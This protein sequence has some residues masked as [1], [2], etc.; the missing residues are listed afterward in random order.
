MRVKSPGI[1]DIVSERF[2]DGP[3][4][5]IEQHSCQ[6]ELLIMPT[7]TARI[8]ANQ[9][10]AAKSTGPKTDEG[11]ARSRL[12][13]F[14][15][16]LAGQ[17]DLIGP[18]DD[19]ALIERRT[20]AFVSELGAPGEVGALFAHRAAVLSVRMENAVV[21]ESK[22]IAESIQAGRDRFDDERAEQLEAW[23]V[24]AEE[25]GAPDIPLFK[26]ETC[27]E[28]LR[29]LRGAWRVMRASVER[30]DEAAT[31]RAAHW[32][33]LCRSDEG[34]PADLLAG[35]DAEITRLDWLVD[36]PIIQDETQL[37][38]T[39]RN[40]AGTI[41]SFDPGPEATLAR[42]YEAAAERGM[43][44]AIR[45]IRELRR[46]QGQNPIPT[47]NLPVFSPTPSI[48]A[49]IPI[50]TP[51]TIPVAGCSSSVAP[52]LTSSLGSFS[53]SDLPLSGRPFGPPIDLH[54]PPQDRPKR[55]KF[56]TRSR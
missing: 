47:V 30:E 7:S 39:R 20:K 35:I 31:H 1:S 17:G 8:A 15:H 40:D 51:V 23:V 3:F 37:I 32:L 26:L 50:P 52:L 42:R 44:R 10:N 45:E 29:Y 41:A 38:R 12:N 19:L 5:P 54:R 48:P 4:S 6:R 22:A 24:E 25:S 43:Y 28:G 34:T 11:K 21:R 9:R 13:A 36:S 56:A 2:A 18:G 14:R 46:D 55:R 27:P 33:G 16:G 49:P 53:G